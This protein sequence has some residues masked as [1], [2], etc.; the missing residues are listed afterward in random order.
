MKDS[1]YVHSEDPLAAARFVVSDVVADLWAGIVR[2]CGMAVFVERAMAQLVRWEREYGW[3][4]CGYGA[5]AEQEV[6]LASVIAGLLPDPDSWIACADA[7]LVQLDRLAPPARA[8]RGG[9]SS[10]ARVDYARARRGDDL[11]VWHS[12]LLERLPDYE[13]A[14]RLVRIA[15]H[16]ALASTRSDIV[17]FQ[18]KVAL[19]G[20]DTE[21]ARALIGA[22]LVELPGHQ[23]FHRLAAEIGAELPENARRVIASRGS[24]S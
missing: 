2:R 15:E 8:G 23:E 16:P 20:G 18:A 5:V 19:L 1:D 13:A 17:A 21:R 22:G 12:M 4:R 10:Y 3:T 11:T 14:D 9:S 24:M 7:Y 6:T